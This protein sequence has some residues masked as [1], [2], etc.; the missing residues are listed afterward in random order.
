MRGFAIAV[1]VAISGLALAQTQEHPAVRSNAADDAPIK[2][3]INPEARVSV[4]RGAALPSSA[5]CGQP[6]ELGVKIVNQGF[7]TAPLEVRLVDSVPEG[8]AVEFPAEP[9]RG[10]P[11]EHRV[12]LLI[13]ENPGP[14]DI[15]IAFRAR[16]DIPDLDGRDRVHF[17]MQCE[18][19]G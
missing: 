13:L 3:T 18:S 10:S 9:L 14:L 8:V 5:I 19:A 15:T 1:T 16:N 6:L 12:L 2:I 4:A 7:V 17:F 11:E